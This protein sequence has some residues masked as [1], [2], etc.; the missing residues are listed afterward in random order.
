[1]SE[2]DPKR[3][4]QQ[5]DD[6]PAA[7]PAEQQAAL[8]PPSEGYLGRRDGAEDGPLQSMYWAAHYGNLPAVAAK[9]IGLHGPSSADGPLMEAAMQG[10][11]E[12]LSILIVA[13]A[14]LDAT[15]KVSQPFPSAFPSLASL[16]LL[17]R[18]PCG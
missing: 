9:L 6:E 16:P 4:K 12:A 14:D 15:R 5:T 18:S 17:P 8:A 1:M 13:G 3:H 7:P 2:P 11:H 10:Q